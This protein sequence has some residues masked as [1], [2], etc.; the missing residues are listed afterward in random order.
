MGA[1]QNVEDSLIEAAIGDAKYE[2]VYRALVWRIPRLPE[3]HHGAYKEHLL[4]C[5]FELS[6]FDLMPE[7]F[8]PTCD[9]EFTMPLAMISNT[10]V[11]SVSVEQH[12]D[13]DR[14]EKFVRYVAK[15]SYKVT[16]TKLLFFFSLS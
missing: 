2:H 16:N 1:V 10:V 11:R 4:R 6:S 14:V 7:A 15:C 13:S 12:D 8:L 9:V 3:K 5:R